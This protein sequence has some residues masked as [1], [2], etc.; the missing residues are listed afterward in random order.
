MTTIADALYTLLTSDDDVEAIVGLKVYP[1]R[2]GENAEA[3]FIV[4]QRI[5]GERVHSLSG[6][7]GLARPRYQIDAYA[8]AYEDAVALG[9]AVRAAIDGYRETVGD[10]QIQGVLSESDQDIFDEEAGLH[11]VSADYFIWHAE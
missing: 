3:P 4:F 2:A 6:P 7:S 1:N 10:L 5:S 8:A 9:D 11:R